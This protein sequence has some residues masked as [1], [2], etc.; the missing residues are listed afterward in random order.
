MHLLT[1]GC[2]VMCDGCVREKEGGE[3]GRGRWRGVYGAGG[4]HKEL[5]VCV[6]VWASIRIV[7]YLND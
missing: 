1:D 5:C 2:E 6:C 4:K 7:N 3:V